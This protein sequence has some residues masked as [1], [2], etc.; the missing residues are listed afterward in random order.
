MIFQGYYF[1][2]QIAYFLHDH[3]GRRTKEIGDSMCHSPSSRFNVRS[4]RVEVASQQEREQERKATCEPRQIHKIS[5]FVSDI[6]HGGGAVM[7]H[8]HGWTFSGTY[9]FRSRIDFLT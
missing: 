9:V 5:A 2:T 8:Y 4:F 1:C 7:L 6:R 3:I